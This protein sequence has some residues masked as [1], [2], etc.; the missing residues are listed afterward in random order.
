MVVL[1][2]KSSSLL[3]DWSQIVGPKMT[4]NLLWLITINGWCEWICYLPY[5]R[6]DPLP[7]FKNLGLMMV[8]LYDWHWLL[9]I[10][11]AN[12]TDNGNCLC[13]NLKW[14]LLSDGVSDS[15][16]MNTFSPIL[17]PDMTSASSTNLPIFV[18]INLVP[19][20]KPKFWSMTYDLEIRTQQ[21]CWEIQACGCR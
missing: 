20:H 14:I 6:L 15:L 5:W 10:V 21:W 11:I 7:A 2:V 8:N 18:I 4:V 19:L 9:L 17:D 12:E 13:L 1:I 16:E 3:R